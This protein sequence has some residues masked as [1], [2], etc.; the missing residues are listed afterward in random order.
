MHF[1]HVP[2]KTLIVHKP[3]SKGKLREFFLKFRHGIE[4]DGVAGR[5]YAYAHQAGNRF[6]AAQKIFFHAVHVGKNELGT[7]IELFACRGKLK[8]STGAVY[9]GDSELLFQL[10]D[11]LGQGR[12]RNVQ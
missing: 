10:L 9:E 4:K 6:S 5:A 12:L 8:A 2:L 3:E 7:M 1:L 11:A